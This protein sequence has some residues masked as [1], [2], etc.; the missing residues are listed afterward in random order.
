[1]DVYNT[2]KGIHNNIDQAAVMSEA[3]KTIGTDNEFLLF[4]AIPAIG[5][6]IMSND[7]SCPQSWSENRFDLVWVFD[8]DVGSGEWSFHQVSQRLLAGDSC[9]PI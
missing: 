3:A 2:V 4:K 9:A 5:N 8:Q 6:S 7:T 1:M